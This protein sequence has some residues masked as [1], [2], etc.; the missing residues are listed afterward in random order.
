MASKGAAPRRFSALLLPGAVFSFL[1][2]EVFNANT[3]FWHGARPWFHDTY[4]A[5]DYV[6][7]LIVAAIIVGLANVRL[8]MPGEHLTR[9]IHILA[10]T[11]FGLYLYHFPLLCFFGS[12][13]SGQVESAPR[14]LL[15]FSLTLGVALALAHMTER[16]K[17]PLSG[18]SAKLSA[19]FPEF[20]R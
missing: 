16:W 19:T 8:P 15:L 11:T 5:Y 12:I 3:L 4:S 13:L 20:A 6:I 14:R 10:G 9:A 18:A 1:C 7:G 2:L 17:I